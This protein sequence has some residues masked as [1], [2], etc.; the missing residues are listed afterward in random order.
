MQSATLHTA[1]YHMQILVHRPFIP[2]PSRPTPKVDFPSLSI[3]THAARSII[4]VGIAQL[5]RFGEVSSTVPV[6][7]AE[8]LLARELTDGVVTKYSSSSLA[9]PS[10]C[11]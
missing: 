8:C 1:F 3:C 5:D 4:H 7:T 6:S 11:S 9:P 10:F 2:S